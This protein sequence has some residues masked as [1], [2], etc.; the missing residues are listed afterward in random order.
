[1]LWTGDNFYRQRY[2]SAVA[3]LLFGWGSA[4]L[5]LERVGT[6]VV[7]AAIDRVIVEHSRKQRG[8][9]DHRIPSM[10]IHGIRVPS[11]RLMLTSPIA[12]ME[13]RKRH[14]QEVPRAAVCSRPS[15]WYPRGHADGAGGSTVVRTALAAVRNRPRLSGEEGWVGGHVVPRAESCR[16]RRGEKSGSEVH[17]KGG[18]RLNLRRRPQGPSNGSEATPA[19]WVPLPGREDAALT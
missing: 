9:D 4:A 11:A 12:F 7:M 15:F 2:F 13:V 19:G 5:E 10:R 1:M 14:H 6:V 17:R 16:T 18:V 3:L 8:H